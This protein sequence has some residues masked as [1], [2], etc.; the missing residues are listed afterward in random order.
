M[1]PDVVAGEAT[2]VGPR[3]ATTEILE[4]A[5]TTVTEETEAGS[6]AEEAMAAT[7]VEVVAEMVGAAE[8]EYALFTRASRR[9]ARDAPAAP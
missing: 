8:T 3:A 1:A 9:R 7:A 5:A 6:M 2:E 4:T